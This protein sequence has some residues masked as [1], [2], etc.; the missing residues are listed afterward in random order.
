MKEIIIAIVVALGILFGGLSVGVLIGREQSKKENVKLNELL[1]ARQ[2]QLKA[3]SEMLTEENTCKKHGVS[4][5]H[6]DTIHDTV[7]IR[8]TVLEQSESDNAK[9]VAQKV[10]FVFKK[11]G[12]H[13][14]GVIC[15]SSGTP[16]F[17]DTLIPV[18]AKLNLKGVL[19]E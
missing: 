18:Y 6:S 9:F 1:T 7:F 5:P 11:Y 4:W 2:S 13:N 12:K 16:L 15:D 8:E 3:L 14:V 10:K 19:H 17:G